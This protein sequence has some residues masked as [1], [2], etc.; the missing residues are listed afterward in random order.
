MLEIR[1]NQMD[2]AIAVMRETAAWGRE[3][4][5]RVWLDEW[6][7]KE[8]LLSEEVGPENFYVGYVEGKPACGFI[9]QWRDQEHWP[10]AEEFEAAYLHKFC[11]RREFAH[12][13]MTKQVLESIKEEC[14]RRGIRYIRLDTGLDE[15]AVRKIYLEAG[16]H[17]VKILDREGGRATALYQMEVL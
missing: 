5:Y 7:T 15:V 17:I 6:L 1:E 10:E 12:H 4:G 9:L 14:R 16:L 11:V 8:A 3:R 2:E 13:N